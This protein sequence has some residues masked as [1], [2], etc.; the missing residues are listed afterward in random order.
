MTAYESHYGMDIWGPLHIVLDCLRKTSSLDKNVR[1]T[2]RIIFVMYLDICY[3][4]AHQAIAWKNTNQQF[5][6]VS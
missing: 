4:P 6:L 2:M 3:T 5:F 1:R